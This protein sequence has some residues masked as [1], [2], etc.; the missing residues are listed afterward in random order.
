MA[1]VAKEGI[2]F[3]GRQVLAMSVLVVKSGHAADLSSFC[4]SDPRH[5]S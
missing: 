5:E 3:G 2:P 1:K 4:T